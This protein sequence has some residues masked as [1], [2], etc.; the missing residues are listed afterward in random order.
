MGA[1]R[2][3]IYGDYV[4]VQIANLNFLR[5]AHIE[6]KDRFS[7][8]KTLFQFRRGNLVLIFQALPGRG[9]NSAERLIIN[10]FTNGWVFSAQ[11]A[12]G[13]FGQFEFIKAKA[14]G[15]KNN[16]PPNQRLSFSDNQ[17]DCFQRL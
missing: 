1:G 12:V 10:Q 4:T 9:N 7:P 8:V 5:L 3:V 15:V 17:F 11:W 6:D 16:Q 14:Q 2:E 13:I